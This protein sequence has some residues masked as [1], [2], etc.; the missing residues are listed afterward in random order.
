MTKS[1]DCGGFI[2]AENPKNFLEIADKEGW[3]AALRSVQENN[4]PNKLQEALAPNRLAWLNL[5]DIEASTRALDIGAGTGGIACQLAKKCSVVAIDGSWNDVKFLKI[6]AEQDNLNQFT[7]LIANAVDIPFD[8]NQF[9]LVTMNGVLEWVPTSYPDKAPR[10]VQLK[11]LRE[12]RRVLKPNG[13]FLLGIENRYYIGYFLGVTEP[14][15]NLKYISIMERDDAEQL[16]QSVRHLPF[17][18]YTYSRKDYENLIREA[19]FNHIETYWLYPDYRLPQYI[20][21]LNN[22]NAVKFFVDGLLKPQDY[23]SNILY[24]IYQ[25]YR[26]CDRKIIGDFVGHYGFVCY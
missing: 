18:E 8:K 20:I 11:T 22:Q 17:L 13:K 16:S 5:V 23:G 15:V 4:S 10:D 14:H 24:S 19:G 9:D 25:F 1:R 26:F 6:R 2:W 12:V 3:Q 7:A 21:P